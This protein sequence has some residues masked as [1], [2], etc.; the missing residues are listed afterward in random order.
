MFK[1][2]ILSAVAYSV[3]NAVDL[4]TE[5]HGGPH[6]R[7]G[8]RRGPTRGLLPRGRPSPH[9]PPKSLP[10]GDS[11]GVYGGPIR[12]SRRLRELKGSPRARRG[13]GSFGNFKDGTRRTGADLDIRGGLVRSPRGYA[14]PKGV[15]IPLRGPARGDLRGHRVRPS[16]LPRLGRVRIGA[17]KLIE[18]DAGHKPEKEE[19]VV[20]VEAD[21]VEV[22]EEETP[23]DVEETKAVACCFETYIEE[24]LDSLSALALLAE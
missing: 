16:T 18:L 11:R 4:D 1:L 20:E 6:G 21:E 13:F 17:P 5:H 19:V 12:R 10:Y 3:V 23:E 15:G 24:S 9:G 7:R 14:S 22:V 8:L 2:A